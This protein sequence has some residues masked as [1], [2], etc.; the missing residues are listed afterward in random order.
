MFWYTVW[1][2]VH[3]THLVLSSENFSNKICCCSFLIGNHI[4]CVPAIIAKCIT[5]KYILFCYL[6]EI[7]VVGGTHNVLVHYVDTCCAPDLAGV[8][9]C[10]PQHHTKETQE[11][12]DALEYFLNYCAAHLE[13]EIIY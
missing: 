5:A 13:A 1:M 8:V 11:T 7:K 4:V 9:I 12:Q 10:N 6:R 2:L 3:P